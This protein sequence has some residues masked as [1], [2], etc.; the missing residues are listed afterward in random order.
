MKQ[1][2]KTKQNLKE[3][4]IGKKVLRQQIKKSLKEIKIGKKVLR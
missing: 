3:I 4:K 2:I 1:K